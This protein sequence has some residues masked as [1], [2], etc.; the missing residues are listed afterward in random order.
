MNP[1][2]SDAWHETNLTIT[3]ERTERQSKSF[4]LTDPILRSAVGGKSYYLK[5]YYG[6]DGPYVWST[7]HDVP[8]EVNYKVSGSGAHVS[9]EIKSK[10]LHPVGSLQSRLLAEIVRNLFTIINCHTSYKVEMGFTLQTSCLGS[11]TEK[12][13]FPIHKDCLRSICADTYIGTDLFLS[14]AS[15]NSVET[16]IQR[17][18]N[19]PLDSGLRY[20]PD[21]F[22]TGGLQQRGEPRVVVTSYIENSSLLFTNNKSAHQGFAG[23]VRGEENMSEQNKQ[24]CCER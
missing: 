7:D 5:N 18:D 2:G 9:H 1:D 11:C 10:N 23:G 19:G 13:E 8:I 17:T 20:Y 6:L 14:A 4:N 15:S 21:G 24:G 3:T 12:Y 22:Y 16:L